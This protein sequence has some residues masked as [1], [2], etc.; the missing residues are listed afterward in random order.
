MFLLDNSNNSQGSLGCPKGI[1]GAKIIVSVVHSLARNVS[2]AFSFC[3][4]TACMHPPLTRLWFLKCLRW[5]PDL[6]TNQQ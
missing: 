6:V 4:T 3:L 2:S 1:A 5:S